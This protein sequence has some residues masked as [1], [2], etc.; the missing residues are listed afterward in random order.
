MK[1]GDLDLLLFLI[2]SKKMMILQLPTVTISGFTYK[3]C[4]L[5]QLSYYFEI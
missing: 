1:I 3:K 5:F 2:I 4:Q